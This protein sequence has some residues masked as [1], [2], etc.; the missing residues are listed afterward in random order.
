MKA[1]ISEILGY[2]PKQEDLEGGILGVVKAYYGC[3]EAQGRGTVHCHM[4]V[5]LEGGLNPN[6][7]KEKALANG[8]DLKFQEKLLAFLD[9]T[10]STSIPSDPDP[11][12]ELELGKI[13][14]CATRGPTES[15]NTRNV[16]AAREKD[17]HNLVK[18]CQFHTHHPTCYKYW[19]GK[20][21]PKECRFDLDE[22]NTAPISVFDPE[23]GE[24]TLRCLDGLV[25]NFNESTI[26]AI[27]CNMDI[28]FIGSGPAAKAIHYYITDYITKTQ[29]Q[30][31]VAYAALELAV[32]R[33][34]EYDANI[35]EYTVRARRLLQKCAHSMIAK[36]E[37]S[38]QQVVSYLMDYEDHFT[39]HKFSSLYWT[40]FEKF[41]NDEDRSPECYRSRVEIPQELPEVSSPEDVNAEHDV[42]SD[43]DHPVDIA[44]AVH[45]LETTE[46]E[47]E[48]GGVDEITLILTTQADLRH[49]QAK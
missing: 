43:L 9:D 31:H 24:L 40:G 42:N 27:R 3:V 39:S 22:S 8:G 25:N 2:D 19:R 16:S 37:L 29:L 13:H 41:I 14:P 20:P 21:E 26:E 35:D 4:L 7:I 34:G 12:F 10:I 5:W 45:S 23:T 1:F 48:E 33:L 15:D 32:G 17:L 11:D 38:A 44:T 18:K 6:Q 30:A 49:Q 46:E 47:E 28:K 36:Q